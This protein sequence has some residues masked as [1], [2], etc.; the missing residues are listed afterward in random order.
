[1][2]NSTY[3]ILRFHTWTM[4]IG[5]LWPTLGLQA[6]N[7]YQD[8]LRIHKRPLHDRFIRISMSYGFPQLSYFDEVTESYASS[9]YSMATSSKPITWNASLEKNISRK[10][11]IGGT[12]NYYYQSHVTGSNWKGL[13]RQAPARHHDITQKLTNQAFRIYADYLVVPLEH[14]DGTRFEFAVG[15]GLGINHTHL[16][17]QQNFVLIKGVSPNIVSVNDTSRHFNHTANVVG[18]SVTTS[19][20]LYL[21]RNVSLQFK[22]DLSIYPIVKV[23]VQQLVYKTSTSGTPVYE[24]ITLRQQF[25]GFSGSIFWMGVHVH[26]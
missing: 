21:S 24:T 10:I 18:A 14:L 13:G 16:Q 25:F 2:L 26:I 11:R 3:A 5:V 8:S 20:D 15:L 22:G 17:G 1:M 12:F 7:E 4:L 23:P 6:Q 19:L 9:G